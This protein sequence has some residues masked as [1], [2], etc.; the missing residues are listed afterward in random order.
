MQQFSKEIKVG[1]ETKLFQ[2]K[3]IEDTNG[4]KFFIT[5]G[6]LTKD[7]FACSMKQN[8]YDT[9]WKLVP[10]SQRWLYEIEDSLSHAIESIQG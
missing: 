5:S 10:G 6:H 8:K 3:R 4:V 7:A 2:F 1:K 9:N